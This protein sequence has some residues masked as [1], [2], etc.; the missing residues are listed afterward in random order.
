V[1]AIAGLALDAGFGTP[2]VYADHG[3]WFAV[4]ERG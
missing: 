4:I 2:G 1:D 3:R